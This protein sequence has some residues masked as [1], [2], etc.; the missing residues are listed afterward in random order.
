MRIG[1]WTSLGVGVSLASACDG[2]T[3]DITPPEKVSFSTEPG[4]TEPEAKDRGSQVQSLPLRPVEIREKTLGKSSPRPKPKSLGYLK[5]HPAVPSGDPSAVKVTQSRAQAFALSIILN[6]GGACR[7][8]VVPEDGWGRPFRVKC[9]GDHGE[10][11]LHSAGPDGVL[12]TDDDSTYTK[13]PPFQV[14]PIQ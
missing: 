12:G 14:I 3:P 1:E 5:R 11:Y 8:R 4:H 10:Y 7:G 9:S 2:S 6:G 13:T